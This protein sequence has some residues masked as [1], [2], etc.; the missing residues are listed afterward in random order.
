M[1]TNVLVDARATQQGY[2]DH[3]A[4]GLGYYG[5]NLLRTLPSVAG[6]T[7][8]MYM[9]EQN[10]EVDP[11][12]AATNVKL[13]PVR[14]PF[15]RKSTQQLAYDNTL[16]PGGLRA[17]GCTIAHFLYH[18]DAPLFSPI[19]TVVTV[20]DLI[21]RLMRQRYDWK[22]RMKNNL[23]YRLEAAVIR[24]AAR[25]IAISEQTK[26]DI[27]SC[28]GIDPDKVSVTHLGVEPRFFDRH[29]D[30]TLEGLRRR[31]RLPERFLL[32]VGGIDPRKNVPA[33]IDA[34]AE[35]ARDEA[36][37]IPLVLAGRL[38]GNREYP[39]LLAHIHERSVDDLVIMPGYVPDEDLP[40][41]FGAAAAFVFPSVYEGFGLPV[42]QSMAAG[43]PAIAARTSSIPEVGGNAVWYVRQAT[44]D[45]FAATVKSVLSSPGRARELCAAGRE[46]AATFSWER[47]ARE[48]F[49][50]YEQVA[51]AASGK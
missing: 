35:L 30:E 33:L 46:R 47:T 17:S 49:A 50:I 37:R 20:P 41:L 32:Y 3:K 4:R 6:S 42:L 36:T 9:I 22:R 24:R 13:H 34:I 18:L 26:T 27:V 10:G 51:E 14:S 2:K 25:V 19:P 38:E 39:D 15:V 40:V 43:C 1:K 11:L 16:L 48:T 21:P 28:V 7:S 31:L 44:A 8:L 29:T 12:I 23:T 5:M 45:E